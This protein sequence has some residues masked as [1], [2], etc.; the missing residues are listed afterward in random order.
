MLQGDSL[1]QFSY[2]VSFQDAGCLWGVEA[3][4]RNVLGVDSR[5]HLRHQMASANFDAWLTHGIKEGQKIRVKVR[6][7]SSGLH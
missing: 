1:K 6:M 7:T 3:C 5:Y 4:L 2:C